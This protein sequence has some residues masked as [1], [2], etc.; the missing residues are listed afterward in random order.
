MISTLFFIKSVVY[1]KIVHFSL[2]VYLSF[3][4]FSSIKR[5]KCTKLSEKR[6]VLHTFQKTSIAHLSKVAQYFDDLHLR[7]IY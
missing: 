2:L 3:L 5:G 7:N 1:I 4:Y 6:Q